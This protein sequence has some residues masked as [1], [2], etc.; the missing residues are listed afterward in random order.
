MK[1][2]ELIKEFY[3]DINE[4]YPSSF[5]M[6]Y[7]KSL[8]TFKD[9]INYCKE[10][11]K[12]LAAG[13]SRIV[14]KIDEKKV[15][16]LAKNEKGLAQ[17]EVE[18]DF[19]QDYYIDNL[20]AKVFEYHP[21]N[22]WV[23]MELATKLTKPKFKSIVGVDFEE[24]SK[25]LLYH[26]SDVVSPNKRYRSPDKPEKMD[27]YWENEFINSMFDFMTNYD[28]PHGD[29]RRLSTYGVVIRNGEETIVMVDYGLTSQVADTYYS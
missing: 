26:H 19:S 2:A 20:V 21:K 4:D 10:H 27:E 13:S 6:D 28:I 15:L 29:L 24:Y 22:L 9:R 3:K 7:F 12:R 25:A 17:N 16:K 11:L 14:Y 8:K 5:D 18:I 1:L 23:E